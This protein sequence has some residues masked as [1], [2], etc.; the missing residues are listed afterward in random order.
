MFLVSGVTWEMNSI[1]FFIES[2]LCGA[3]TCSVVSLSISCEYSNQW[4]SWPHTLLCVG[5]FSPL[6]VLLFWL[7]LLS[8]FFVLLFR[9]PLI[10]NLTLPSLLISFQ[11]FILCVNSSRKSRNC[12]LGFLACVLVISV[13]TWLLLFVF[14]AFH[15]CLSFLL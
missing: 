3:F 2:P 15:G 10:S 14:T 4:L 1:L 6:C 5:P 8:P 11:S 9:F 13:S 12:F 7:F